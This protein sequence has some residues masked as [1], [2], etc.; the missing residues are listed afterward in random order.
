MFR[1]LNL[2]TARRRL[3]VLYLLATGPLLLLLAL[4]TWVDRDQALKAARSQAESIAHVGA[5]Q[6]DELIQETYTLLNVLALVPAI[7]GKDCHPLLERIDGAHPRITHLSLFR[8]DGTPACSSRQENPSGSVADRDDFNRALAAAPGAAAASDIVVSRVSGLPGIVVA[9][10][11][12]DAAGGVTGVLSAALNLTG[13][14]S[15]AQRMSGMAETVVDIVDVR[16]GTSLVRRGAQ[17]AIDPELLAAIRA[18]PGGGSLD[19]PFDGVPHT[20]AFTPLLGVARPTVLVIGLPRTEVLAPSNSHLTLGALGFGGAAVAAI[21]LAWLAAARSLLQPIRRMVAAAG[22]IGCGGVPTR[23]GALPGAVRELQMLAQ[24][25]DDMAER[26]HL[27]D[28]HI[29]RMSASLADSEAHHRLLADHA[30]DMIARFDPAFVRT[31]ISPACLDI[32]GYSPGEMVGKAM[33]TVVLQ[34]DRLRVMSELVQPLL[35]GAATARCTYRIFRSD[36]RV[37]WLETSGRRLPDASGFVTVARDVSVQ[38]ALEAELE[39]A[40]GQLRI[41]VMQDPLTGI[42]NRRRFDELLGFEFRRARRQDEPMS[43]LLAD[44]DHFKSFNDLYGHAVG[45]ECL[46]AVA[47]A[48]ER[49]L[50]RPGDMAGRYGGEEFAILLPGIDEAGASLVAERLRS[51][52][53]SIRTDAFAP[54]ARQVTVSVGIATLQPGAACRGPSALVEAA[55]VALYA[56]KNAGRNRAHAAPI[57]EM[58]VTAPA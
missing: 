1:S 58:D 3:V 47:R 14:E 4:G 20:V 27:R 18:G 5:A 56:A 39:A 16:G 40:N 22:S 52:V 49:T 26:L 41:Q 12:R 15:L 36:G 35:D 48:L 6:Q 43:V 34:A 57:A 51:A 42:A 29:A 33:P 46:R 45:D 37:V 50:R 30:S 28:A 2:A 53:E 55:D 24:S 13:L 8:P 44:I 19:A 38:K 9:V 25:F 23:V 17:A 11:V 32:I 21:I 54:G 7:G 10:P 31:Y